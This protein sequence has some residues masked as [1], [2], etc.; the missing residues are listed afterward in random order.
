MSKYYISKKKLKEIEEEL[1][2]LKKI[3]KESFSS[4]SPNIF[5]GEDINPDFTSYQDDLSNLD[6]RVEELENILKNYIIIEAP[7]EKDKVNLGASVIFKNGSSKEEELKIV[8]TLEANPFEGKISN[9]SPVGMAFLGK[10]IGDV[11]LVGENNSYK[12]TNIRYEEI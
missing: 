7:E 4:N 6:F 12:I 1:E 9:E 2:N 5:E 3:R 8:G 11:V 10:K